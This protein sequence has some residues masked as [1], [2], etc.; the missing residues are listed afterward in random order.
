MPNC[1]DRNAEKAAGL[2]LL[3]IADHLTTTDPTGVLEQHSLLICV[4]AE[5]YKL[6]DRSVIGGADELASAALAL[7]PEPTGGLTRGEFALR[8]R[9]LVGK[10][11][12]RLGGG[13]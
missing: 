3:A 8:L 13:R 1:T 5:A 6:A 9:R 12:E 2:V 11:G 10:D 7:A 4:G